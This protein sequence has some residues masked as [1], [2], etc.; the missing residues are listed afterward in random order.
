MGKIH[1]QLSIEERVMIQTQLSQVYKA[2][3]I[4]SELERSEPLFTTDA[5]DFRQ[6]H[7]ALLHL[8][9]KNAGL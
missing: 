3:K 7:A 8:V 4:A 1:K 5:F 9:L 6:H 2:E